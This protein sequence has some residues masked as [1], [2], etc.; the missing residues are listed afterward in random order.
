[1]SDLEIEDTS[2]E[3]NSTDDELEQFASASKKDFC[4][5]ISTILVSADKGSFFRVPMVGLLKFSAVIMVL[6]SLVI[7]YQMMNSLGENPFF[8]ATG[9][10]VACI[11]MAQVCWYRASNLDKAESS[12][13]PV[14]P[15]LAFNLKVSGEC[16]A[17]MLSIMGVFFS[18]YDLLEKKR[19]A[20]GTGSDYYGSDY[21]SGYGSEYA[22][23]MQEAASSAEPVLGGPL[24]VLADAGVWAVL[25]GPLTGFLILLFTHYLAELSVALVA[26]ANNTE[27]S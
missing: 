10:V 25:V 14:T 16:L 4:F 5:P 6:G 27:K 20:S 12:S 17:V 22:Y 7:W 18:L 3:E 13:Y 8:I 11:G 26:I 2:V 24:G 23:R 21:G 9:I 1:M 19:S 15:L